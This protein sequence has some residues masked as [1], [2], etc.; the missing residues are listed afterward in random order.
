MSLAGLL[1]STPV[2]NPQSLQ[3]LA[4]CGTFCP[5]CLAFTGELSLQART[6][7]VRLRKQGFLQ[8]A[9]QLNPEEKPVIDSFF[10]VL[11]RLAR[12]PRCPGCAE[13]G[14]EAECPVRRCCGG[15]GY[16]TCAEC[17][18]LERCSQGKKRGASE[19]SPGS[20]AAD[21]RRVRGETF[22][23]GDASAFFQVLSHKYRGWNVDNLK[24]AREVGERRVVQELKSDPDFRTDRVKR[25]DSPGESGAS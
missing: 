3:H 8:R 9:A 23:M 14:G 25:E 13:G 16:G 10:E 7:L 4:P 11:D 21:A 24:R 22:S 5:A 18:E 2:M 12:S 17:S 19:E 1:Y 20:V 6:L 15:R